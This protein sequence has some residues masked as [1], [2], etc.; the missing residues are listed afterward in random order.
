MPPARFDIGAAVEQRLALREAEPD[1]VGDILPARLIG[2][3][4]RAF[5]LRPRNPRGRLPIGGAE[6]MPVSGRQR[7]SRRCR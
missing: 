3:E 6:T 1:R 2:V 4:E 7:A 5:E